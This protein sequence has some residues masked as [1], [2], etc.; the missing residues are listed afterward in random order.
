MYVPLRPSG[1]SIAGQT[2]WNS[3]RDEEIRCVILIALSG[4]LAILFSLC[5]YDQ[6]IRG[7][8]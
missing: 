4:Y 2:V 5:Y 8:F 6:R 7:F 1:F 3:L